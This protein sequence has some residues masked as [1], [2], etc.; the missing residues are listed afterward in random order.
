MLHGKRQFSKMTLLKVIFTAIILAELMPSE[1]FRAQSGP[2][3]PSLNGNAWQCKELSAV[4]T[5]IFRQTQSH[6]FISDDGNM[7]D[8][9]FI[10]NNL[11]QYPL[12][13]RV[14]ID[15]HRGVWIQQIGSEIALTEFGK[16]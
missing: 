3:Q 11:N 16:Q 9:Q 13:G 7:L 8:V 1:P 15:C 14:L 4:K 10:E 6:A 12:C 5:E 2:L